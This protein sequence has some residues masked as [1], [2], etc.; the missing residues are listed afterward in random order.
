MNEKG[1]F[2]P[3]SILIAAVLISGSV[4][5]SGLSKKDVNKN[6]VE[7]NNNQQFDEIEPIT[8]ADYIRGAGVNAKVAIV[9]Y[10][11]PECPFCST[12]HETMKKIVEN[13]GDQVAWVYRH[14]PLDNLHDKARIEIT[15]TECAND[16][17]GV[18]AFWSYLDRLY[19]VTP[20]NDGLDL[21]ELPVIADYA[22][23]NINHFNECL[24]SGKFDDKIE[25]YYQ[26]AIQSGGTGTPYVLLVKDGEVLGDLG[27]AKP[28]EY[29]VEVLDNVLNEE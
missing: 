22:G 13:Y 3:A 19:E 29:F 10:S 9:E 17:G 15:A 26:D 2:L 6:N 20:S 25:A 24:E 8:E 27:G 4:I 16:L 14:F 28:Y 11:D 12:F 23:L 21:E 5:W 7:E 1:Y 18:D